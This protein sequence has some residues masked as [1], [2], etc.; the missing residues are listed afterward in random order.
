MCK[1]Q[2]WFWSFQNMGIL[3]WRYNFSV[4]FVDFSV[5]QLELS[6]DQVSKAKTVLLFSQQFLQEF[7]GDSELSQFYNVV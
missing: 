7:Q 5:Q 1:T 3:H 2:D 6:V 4:A